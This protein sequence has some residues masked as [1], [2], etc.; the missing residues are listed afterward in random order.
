[1]KACRDLATLPHLPVCSFCCNHC[2]IGRVMPV[3]P[4]GDGERGYSDHQHSAV[5]RS[6]SASVSGHCPVGR[7]TPATSVEDG[8]CSSSNLSVRIYVVSPWRFTRTFSSIFH[9]SVLFCPHCTVGRV[10]PATSL[11]DGEP[12]YCYS[13]QYLVGDRCNF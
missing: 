1:M 3:V 12:S 4:V 11:E 9:Q 13:D 5:F 8:E 2:P 10:A 6:H 7:V